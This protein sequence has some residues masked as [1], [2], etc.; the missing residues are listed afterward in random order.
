[1]LSLRCMEGILGR[2]PEFEFQWFEAPG[3]RLREKHS[4]GGIKLI[5]V[6]LND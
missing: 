1:M 3:N 4:I 6:G 5:F 2:G